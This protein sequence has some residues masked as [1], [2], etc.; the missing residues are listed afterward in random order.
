MDLKS[1]LPTELLR[2]G[3]GGAGTLS[4]KRLLKGSFFFDP[5]PKLV[6]MFIIWLEEKAK[7]CNHILKE[8]MREHQDTKRNCLD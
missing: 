3:R 4:S 5:F 8:F 2:E 7:I 1:K 6:G